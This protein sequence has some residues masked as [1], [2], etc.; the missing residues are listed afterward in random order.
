V[1]VGVSVRIH[2]CFTCQLLEPWLGWLVIDPAI[3]I[4]NWNH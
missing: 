3:Q 4:A 2:M 1:E